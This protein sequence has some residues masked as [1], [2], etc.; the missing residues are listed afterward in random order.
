MVEMFNSFVK[1]TK[2]LETGMRCKLDLVKRESTLLPR[3][4]PSRLLSRISQVSRIV[5]PPLSSFSQCSSQQQCSYELE[6]EH[7]RIHPT[8]YRDVY[9]KRVI[10]EF[11]LVIFYLDIELKPVSKRLLLFFFH[12]EVY[13][14]SERRGSLR[15]VKKRKEKEERKKSD[16]L[17]FALLAQRSRENLVKSSL[18]RDTD[19]AQVFN[20]KVMEPLCAPCFAQGGTQLVPGLS[21]FQC[22]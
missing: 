3:N 13:K 19:R 21:N 17:T 8:R 22:N 1:R 10:R 2:T 20:E 5:S 18:M 6:L 9:A 16:V 4:L 11:F 14:E 7:S 15:Y 12:L